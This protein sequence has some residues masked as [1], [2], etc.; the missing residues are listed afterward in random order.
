MSHKRTMGQV[1]TVSSFFPFG[2]RHPFHHGR[3][4][5]GY[6]HDDSDDEDGCSSVVEYVEFSAAKRSFFLSSCTSPCPASPLPS[7]TSSATPRKRYRIQ[8]VSD[9]HLEHRDNRI[10]TIPRLAPYLALLGDIGYPDSYIYKAFLHRMSAQFEKVF[11]LCGNH[12]FYTS[13]METTKEAVRKVCSEKDN[14]FF[15]DRTSMWL[16]GEGSV[17]ILGCTLWSHVTPEQTRAVANSLND[18]RL[19]YEDAAQKQRGPFAKLLRVEHTNKIHA[20][21][22]AWLEENLRIAKQQEEEVVVL[23]HHAPIL[24]SCHPKYHNSPISSAFATDLAAEGLISAPMVAWA[25]GHTHYSS[26]VN[27]NGVKVLSNAMGYP[28]EAESKYNSDMVLE[29]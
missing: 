25:Y 24:N 4:L 11:V 20:E 26:V 14:L 19:I 29:V 3:A 2:E 6:A 17:R 23:T 28:H 15:L 21:E 7:P 1:Q 8:I 13:D 18:Y 5:A 16:D 27:V 10:P 12:E 9:V 22:K